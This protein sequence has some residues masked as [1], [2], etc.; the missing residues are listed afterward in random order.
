MSVSENKNLVQRFLESLSGNPKPSAI[1]DRFV[2][3]QPL[4]DRVASVEIGFPNYTLEAVEMIAEG[5]LVAVKE[6]FK[7]GHLGIFNGIHGTGQ[8]VDLCFLT[9]FQIYDGKIV[10]HWLWIDRMDV[11]HQL[12]VIP[13]PS[14]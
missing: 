3:E 8:N 7:G 5:D 4:K 6:R 1:V 11:M 14:A 10:D 2:T 12:G 9:T 13:Q